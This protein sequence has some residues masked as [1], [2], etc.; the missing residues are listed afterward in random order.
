LT[1]WLGL[2]LEDSIWI[3]R[4]LTVDR[5]DGGPRRRGALCH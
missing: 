5:A 3:A 4:G 2:L 1:I